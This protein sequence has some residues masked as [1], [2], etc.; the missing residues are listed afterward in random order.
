MVYSPSKPEA[1]PF[2]RQD[3][4]EHKRRIL[5]VDDNDTIRSLVAEHFKQRDYSVV[6]ARDG[7]DRGPCDLFGDTHDMARGKLC[8]ALLERDG[9][10]GRANIARQESAIGQAQPEMAMLAER[11][12][13][14][15]QCR[16]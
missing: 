11:D 7:D 4:A 2:G 3:M 12:D 10:V 14:A 1:K 15:Q 9:A 16:R 6:E 8:N 13:H 5:I